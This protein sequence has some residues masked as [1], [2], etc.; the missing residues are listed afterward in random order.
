M[1]R[2]IPRHDTMNRM[3]A[4]YYGAMFVE[5]REGQ[6]L[7]ELLIA[8]AIGAVMFLGAITVVAPALKTS[9]QVAQSQMAGT[10][11][12]ELMDNVRV[13]S[14]N[15]WHNILSLSKTSSSP[16]YLIIGSSSI[17]VA[18]GTESVPSDGITSGLIGAWRFDEGSGPAVMDYS[19]SDSTGTWNGGGTHYATGTMGPY[20]AQFDGSDDYVGMASSTSSVLKQSFANISVSAWVYPTAYQSGTLVG[21]AI[22]SNTHTFPNGGWG[23][24]IR[25]GY[26]TV[27]LFTGSGSFVQQI[28][29]TKVPL[30]TW[31]HVAMV[32]DGFLITAYINGNI[33][34]TVG[35]SGAITASPAGSCTLIG[36]Q[37]SYFGGGCA[38][39]SF[40]SEGY[41][42]GRMDD[43]RVYNRALSQSEVQKIYSG[44]THTRYFY[45]DNVTRNG[46]GFIDP[47]GAVNDPST[48]KVTVI[49]SWPQ[50]SVP[51]SFTSY[52][53]RYRST[54]A[55]QTNWSGG[56]GDG[57]SKTNFGNT[58]FNAANIDYVSS[59]GSIII[60]GY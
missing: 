11:A 22:L 49:Y 8:V 48:Q 29:T 1:L 38:P 16:Y 14:E 55:L 26:P 52:V 23:F 58:F 47:A 10:A 34:G 17:A 51:R 60:Q 36:V 27:N 45:V 3:K 6:S 43:L 42:Q 40:P 41:F 33:V 5:R 56:G 46:S 54:V 50:L 25:N 30:N 57:G 44:G 9:S 37:P 13:W 2:A 59:T 18:S 15:D 28:G 19:G 20:A 32:Y 12:K 31:S 7:A 21:P 4:S 24:H 35:E 53:T 39:Q